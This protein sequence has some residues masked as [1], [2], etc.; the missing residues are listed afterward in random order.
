MLSLTGVC[1]SGSSEDLRKTDE[2][3]LNVLTSLN[4]APNVPERIKAQYDDNIFWIKNAENNQ[5][6][7]GSE[8]RILYANSE[9]RSNISVAFND[10]IAKGEIKGAIVLSRDHHDVSGTDSPFRETSNIT[11]GSMYCADM[12]IQNVIGDSFRGATWVAIHN[13]GGVGWGEVING[14]FGMVLDGSYEAQEKAKSMLFWDV[15][16]G[17]TRRAWDGND[18]ANLE[19][20]RAMQRNPHLKVTLGHWAGKDV[21]D[22][23]CGFASKL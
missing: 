14:G 9:A 6:V 18:N 20:R 15:N 16:N 21:L 22:K 11:D 1:T 12:A 5:L 10:A 17:I 23:A 19:I 3:A 7:V 8:A 2:I 13:G 4:N